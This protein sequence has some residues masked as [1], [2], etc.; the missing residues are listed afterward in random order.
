MENLESE[1]RQMHICLKLTLSSLALVELVKSVI[2]TVQVTVFQE[3]PRY[4]LPTVEVIRL[5]HSSHVRLPGV[6]IGFAHVCDF[7]SVRFPLLWLEGHMLGEV[8]L[9]A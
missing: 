6:S 7:A 9:P 4:R 1:K 8:E 5:L 3:T 2:D